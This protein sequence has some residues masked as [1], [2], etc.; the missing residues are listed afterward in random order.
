LNY[1]EALREEKTSFASHVGNDVHGVDRS[2]FPFARTKAERDIS[3]GGGEELP[4]ISKRREK[5]D[6]RGE[7][8]KGQY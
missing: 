7:G 1:G 5:I 8:E 4:A 6:F 2:S 3:K